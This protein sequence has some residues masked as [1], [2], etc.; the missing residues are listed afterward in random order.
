MPETKSEKKTGAEQVHWDLSDLYESIDDPQLKKDR[1]KVIDNADRFAE[2]YKGR[3]EALSAPELLEALRQYEEILEII[4]KIG[5]YSHLKWTTNT[6]DA[7]LGK[8]MQEANELSSQVKQKLVFFDVEWLAI[9]EDK[10]RA[11]INNSTLSH[12]RH[13]LETSRRYKDHVLGEEA[14]QVLSAKNVTGRSAWNR[15]KR[16][17]PPGTGAGGH[18]GARL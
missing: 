7:D 5:S 15:P 4:G 13:Y 12:Y 17:K 1:Q 2:Q 16:E 3:V 14:E 11:L 6:E 8:L 10:A 9:E 18:A